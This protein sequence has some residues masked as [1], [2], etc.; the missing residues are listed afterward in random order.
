MCWTR[1]TLRDDLKE[2]KKS[3]LNLDLLRKKKILI[4]TDQNF[5][6][7]LKCRMATFTLLILHIFT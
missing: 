3:V 6:T 2:V 1:K 7:A 4:I 5:Y